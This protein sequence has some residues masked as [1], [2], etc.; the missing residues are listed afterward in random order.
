MMQ[1]PASYVDGQPADAQTL[2]VRNSC[3]VQKVYDDN[4]NNSNVTVISFSE[5]TEVT[6][7]LASG[8][9]D[10]AGEV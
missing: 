8:C 7:G 4:N 2:Q 5:V 6:E 10:P 3:L 9:A 1:A